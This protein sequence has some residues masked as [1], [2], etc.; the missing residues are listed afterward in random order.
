[1]RREVPTTTRGMRT[2]ILVA[3]AHPDLHDDDEGGVWGTTIAE[4]IAMRADSFGGWSPGLHGKAFDRALRE[5]REE[6]YVEFDDARGFR[7]AWELSPSGRPIGEAYE[8]AR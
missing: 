2:A 7:V 1:M 6:G 4:Y 3:F 8:E 5:L